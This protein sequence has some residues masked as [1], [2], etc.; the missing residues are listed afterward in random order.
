VL[1]RLR[2][3]RAQLAAL[4]FN[5]YGQR[6]EKRCLD[7]RALEA[8]QRAA[9]AAPEWSVPWYNIGL[10]HKYRGD[11]E[12]SM[13]ANRRAAQLDAD[14]KAAWWNYGIA[15]TALE[16]W[17][18]ARK[19]WRGFGFDLPEDNGEVSLPCGL[20]PIRVNPA[21][22]PEVVW[23][24]RI[25]PAR[26]IIRNV[27]LP[28]SQRHFGDLLLHDGAP[29][30]FRKHGDKEL[31]VFDELQVL[32]ASAYATY[33]AVIGGVDAAQLQ[34]L[35]QTLHE[36]DGGYCE[37]WTDNIRMLCKACSEGR[38]HDHARESDHA[39]HTTAANHELEVGIASTDGDTALALLKRWIEGTANAELREFTCVLSVR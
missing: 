25:D 19:A 28:Q 33:K 31:A 15:A 7:E 4:R 11:W 30:G 37:V 39:L 24:D 12:K 17:D 6:L 34:R 32:K 5:A 10:Q 8:Y 18:D 14:N 38:P 27:P 3:T 23:C 36:S 22:A 16:A 29:N 1:S 2:R 13:T 20:T 9:K 26:A 35:E 21:Q